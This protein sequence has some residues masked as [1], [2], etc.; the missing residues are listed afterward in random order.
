MNTEW[1]SLIVVLILSPII[2]YQSRWVYKD[3]EKNGLNKWGWGIF[4]LLN[5][6][7]NWLI[8]LLYKHL[9]LKNTTK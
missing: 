6:P 5:T 8:Y 9:K 7:S 2:I 3:A 1:S 4:C